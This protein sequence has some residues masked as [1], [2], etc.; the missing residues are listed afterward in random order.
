MRPRI[1]N[2]KVANCNNSS[3][4][5]TKVGQNDVDKRRLKASKEREHRI[6]LESKNH[7]RNRCRIAAEKAIDELF[8]LNNKN[9]YATGNA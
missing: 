3:I 2:L 4:T 8:N 6:V 5:L 7:A 9:N 1:K